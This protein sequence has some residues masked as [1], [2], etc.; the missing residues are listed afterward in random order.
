MDVIFGFYALTPYRPPALAYL[1]ALLAVIGLWAVARR[2]PVEFSPVRRVEPDSTSLSS[3]RYFAAGLA[4]AIASSPCY[5]ESRTQASPQP[6]NM[7][8]LLLL[9]VV[10]VLA[11]RRNETASRWNARR[12]LALASGALS[13]FICSGAA[14]TARPG[15]GWRRV[16]GMALVGFGDGAL[17]GMVGGAHV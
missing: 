11:L 4:G 13:F 9:V 14:A 10:V 7:T 1:L 3:L 15:A 6:R 16:L 17:P 8:L 2:M 5:G 12:Q